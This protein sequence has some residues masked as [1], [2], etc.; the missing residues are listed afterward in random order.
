MTTKLVR[1]HGDCR[2]EA[3]GMPDD[4]YVMY[5]PLNAAGYTHAFRVD[6]G[7]FGGIIRQ[8]IRSA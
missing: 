1:A 5:P 7:Q 4:P 6:V 8:A 2:L 3:L